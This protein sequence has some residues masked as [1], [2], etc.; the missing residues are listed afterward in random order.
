MDILPLW[1]FQR[2]AAV[3]IRS[4]GNGSA[5]HADRGADNRL[6]LVIHN[7]ATTLDITRCGHR[8]HTSEPDDAGQENES[9]HNN[10]LVELIEKYSKF[11]LFQHRCFDIST[12][13]NA[14]TQN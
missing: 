3:D 11:Y 13:E 2:E 1:N 5:G 9:L 14:K 4:S 8:S 10:D 6:A 7:D 12:P